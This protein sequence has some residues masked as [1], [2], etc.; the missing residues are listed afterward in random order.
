MLQTNTD[1]IQYIRLLARRSEN[2]ELKLCQLRAGELLCEQYRLVRNVLFINRGIAKAYHTEENT[3]EFVLFIMGEGEAIGDWEALGNHRIWVNSVVALTDI[4]FF[5]MAVPDFLRLCD[6]DHKLCRML[7]TEISRQKSN[8]LLRASYQLQNPMKEVLKQLLNKVEEQK[9]S[10][11]KYD[12][13]SYLGIELR[14]VNRLLREIG[15]KN[16]I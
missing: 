14:S 12:M 3:K 1:I 9:I 5:S 16:G 4:E 11:T 6:N 15:N 7:L 13:A 10:L 2:C 8:A